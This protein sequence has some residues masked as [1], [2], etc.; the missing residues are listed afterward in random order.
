M[1]SINLQTD[2]AFGSG[3]QDGRNDC[4]LDNAAEITFVF[5]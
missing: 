4:R 5:E 1:G 2:V 3:G